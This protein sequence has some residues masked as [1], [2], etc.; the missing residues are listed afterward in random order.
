MVSFGSGDP[1]RRAKWVG[2]MAILTKDGQSA[3]VLFRTREDQ[4]RPRVSQHFHARFG[5]GDDE[6]EQS[7]IDYSEAA[8]VHVA[9]TSNIRTKKRGRC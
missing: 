5:R 7:D 9:W 1:D 4:R 3:E 6:C 2:G 8:R